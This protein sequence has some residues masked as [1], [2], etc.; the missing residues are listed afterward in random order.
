MSL[1]F[2]PAPPERLADIDRLIRAAFAPYIRALGREISPDAY[3]WFAEAIA[4]GD[5][6]AASDGTDIAG[7]IVT[8]RHDRDLELALIGVS[9]QR[10]KQGIAGWMIGRIEELARRRG[11]A[12]LSLNTAEMMTDRVR[13]YSRHGFEIV[14]RG[15]PTHGKDAHTRVYMEKALI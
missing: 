7:A 3:G 10:Q 8:R 9:P 14:G 13:L 4:Q 11:Y 5:I 15:P 6:Y 1:V 2:A 12:T